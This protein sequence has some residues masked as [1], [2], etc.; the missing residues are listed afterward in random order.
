M[1]TFMDKLVHKVN[2]QEIIK[3]NMAAETARMEQLQSQV[4]AYEALLKDMRKVNTKT[5]E[6]MEQMKNVLQESISKIEEVQNA[7]ADRRDLE[8][9]IAQLKQQIEEAFVRSDDFM[10][11][12]SV[13]VY[14]NVQAAMIEEMGKQTELLIQKQKEN[15]GGKNV[16]IALSIVTILLVIADIVI[17]LLDSGII[18][19]L[20][21]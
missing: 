10:H 8:E 6:N 18:L 12:E 15:S 19:S 20:L 21:P 11:K 3:A 1:D 4:E 13:K 5:V 17:H 16:M 2:A 9:L 7:N 14:R